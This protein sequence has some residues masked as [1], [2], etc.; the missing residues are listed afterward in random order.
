MMY[1]VEKGHGGISLDE[2]KKSVWNGIKHLSS[3]KEDINFYFYFLAQNK[4]ASS[5][6]KSIA[7]VLDLF[8]TPVSW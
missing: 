6:T 8:W 4:F 3:I 2:R 1:R 7:A 5:T